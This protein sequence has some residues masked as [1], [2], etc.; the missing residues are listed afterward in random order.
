MTTQIIY[1]LNA[2]GEPLMPTHR[3]GKVRRWLSCGEAHWF[4]NSRTTIQFDRPVEN[5][6]QNC[7][8]GIDLGNHIGISVVCT[9]TN[10]ELYNGISQRDYQGEVK[11]N[12]KRREHRR[13]RRNRL[14]HRKA[15]F[16]NRRRPDGWLAP[17][18]QHYIDFTI[19]EILRIQKFL[20]I[21]KV[22]LETSV[23]DTAKLTN[24]GIRPKDY[25]K[26][27]LHGY[28]SLKEYL[29]DQQN[30]I[31][32]IDGQHYLLSEMVVHHLQYRSQGGTNSPDN[33]ILLSRKNH[34]TTNHNN[35]ILTD[36]AKHHQDSLVNTKGAF[37]MNIMHL[38]LPKILNNKPLQ[39]TFGYKTAQQRTLYGFKKDRN[40]LIN[41]VVDALLIANGNNHTELMTDIIHREK[42]HRNNR[43]LEK[44]YDAKYYS[45]VDGKVYSGKEL[46]SG[47]TNRK[48]PRT[49]NSKRFERGC[50][51]SKGRRPIRHQ[52]YQFQPHDKILWQDKI[53]KCK[54]TMNRGKSIQFWL[55]N[56]KTKSSKPSKLKLLHHAN[57]W[58]IDIIDYQ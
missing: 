30:G 32:P 14:R 42:H 11:R 31:D 10:Q 17:S 28:N 56:G 19:N 8:E 44:F 6:T 18:I 2:N 47:R 48:Q 33:T 15:R 16:D 22:I 9:T 39:L 20:P 37:L 41:H 26:G 45:N 54:T 40:N 23:F 25:T 34:N 57:H 50:K 43:S 36:L 3:L 29:Y 58:K 35:G 46:G 52:H 55:P 12:I 53:V 38:R 51:K 13:N 7:I 49:Y 4:G 27:R 1:V 24:F 5:T 21:S